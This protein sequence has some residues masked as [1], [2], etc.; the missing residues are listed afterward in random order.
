MKWENGAKWRGSR[1]ISGNKRKKSMQI[2]NSLNVPPNT[3]KLFKIEINTVTLNIGQ[4]DIYLFFT[5][6]VDSYPKFGITLR[7]P[8]FFFFVKRLIVI[9]FYH[10][11]LI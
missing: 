7:F 8:G 1:E 6:L 11:H 2:D 4:Y 5:L 10:L 3:Q 9:I